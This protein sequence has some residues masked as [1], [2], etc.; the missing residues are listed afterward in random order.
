MCRFGTRDLVQSASAD[1]VLLSKTRE[2]LAHKAATSTAVEDAD[3]E[4]DLSQ[5]HELRLLARS[6]GFAKNNQN[7]W[8]NPKNLTP[9]LFPEREGEPEFGASRAGRERDFQTRYKRPRT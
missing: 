4:H 8:W 5:R 6:R 1:N 9:N 7:V 2:K 3:L